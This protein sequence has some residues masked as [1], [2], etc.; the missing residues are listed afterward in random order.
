[1]TENIVRRNGGYIVRH[2]TPPTPTACISTPTQAPKPSRLIPT[3]PHKTSWQ[4]RH[5]WYTYKWPSF[6]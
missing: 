2:N 5:F 6:I 1:M 3:Y 4:C